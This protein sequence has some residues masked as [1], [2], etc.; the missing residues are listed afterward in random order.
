MVLAANLSAMFDPMKLDSPSEFRT[1]RAAD[2]YILWGYG[3]HTC[4]G[5]HIN[6]AMIPA[7][8]K[9]LLKTTG[10]RRAEG[11]QGVVDT[12]GTPFPAH[13]ILEFDHG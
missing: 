7:I 13:L 4:F 5:E 11:K 2:D 1:D 9:P 6:R 10:L 12:A 8:L 3:L